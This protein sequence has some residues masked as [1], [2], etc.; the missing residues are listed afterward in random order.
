[1]NIDFF[2]YSISLNSIVET[3]KNAKKFYQNLLV[4]SNL[5]QNLKRIIHTDIIITNL[6]LAHHTMH[7]NY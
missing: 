3:Y 5:S 7:S 4:F 2:K 1:M 6:V